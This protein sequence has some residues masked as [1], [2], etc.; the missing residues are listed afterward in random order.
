MNSSGGSLMISRSQQRCVEFC[1]FSTFWSD[2]VRGPQGTSGD[3]RGVRS[4]MKALD[5]RLPGWW[6][7]CCAG[8]D[9]QWFAQPRWICCSTFRCGFLPEV[10]SNR[11]CSCGT[12]PWGIQ[13]T[14][15]FCELWVGQMKSDE[16]N[17]SWHKDLIALNVQVCQSSASKIYRT[18]AMARATFVKVCSSRCLC[19]YLLS[20]EHWILRSGYRSSL[21]HSIEKQLHSIFKQLR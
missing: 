20:Q 3:L 6:V 10:W 11:S 2:P 13:L 12:S 7:S 19:S 4:I 17:K 8:E 18:S 1:D 5:P 21:W 14:L 9:G 16:D 15:H